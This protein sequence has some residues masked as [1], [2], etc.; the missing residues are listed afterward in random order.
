MISFQPTETDDMVFSDTDTKRLLKDIISGN[1]S[2]PSNGKSTLLLFGSY[3]SGKT[4]YAN[5][6]FNEYEER[7]GGKEAYV[8]CL[9]NEGGEMITEQVARLNK[10]CDLVSFNH[11][12]KHYIIFDEVD[13]YTEKQQQRL[14]SFLNRKDIIVLMTTNNLHKI[15]LGIQSRSYLIPFNASNNAYDYVT[16]IKAIITQ[17]N[18]PMISD[19]TL[20]T[21]AQQAEGDW[22]QICSQ[23]EQV[24][25]S[26]SVPPPKQKAK[27]QVVK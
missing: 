23:V 17:N 19:A 26:I 21:I 27:L 16:R 12:N 11:S 3:G 25:R 10:T 5:I 7:F 20:V 6:F 22:R 1:L 8:D 13:N 14:K 18:L 2:F 9:T 15:D 4:T 24:C